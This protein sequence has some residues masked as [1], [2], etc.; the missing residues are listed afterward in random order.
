MPDVRP[1]RHELGQ[2]LLTDKAVLDRIVHLASQ[3]PVRGIA[4]GHCRVPRGCSWVRGP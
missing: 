2:N 1:G 3:W 4:C